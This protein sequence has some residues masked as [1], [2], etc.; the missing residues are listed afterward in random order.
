MPCNFVVLLFLQKCCPICFCNMTHHLI[1]QQWSKFQVYWVIV[2]S[3]HS[4]DTSLHC[5]LP[6]LIC[7]C[8]CTHVH[9]VHSEVSLHL[10]SQ[11]QR[12]RLYLYFK[13][14]IRSLPRQDWRGMESVSSYTVSPFSC[15][16]LHSF[17]RIEESLFIYCGNY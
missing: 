9:M 3:A 2:S 7:N 5:H 15:V 16:F 11:E 10:Q 4:S 6:F 14:I 1:S 13:E 12:L 17:T 8:I